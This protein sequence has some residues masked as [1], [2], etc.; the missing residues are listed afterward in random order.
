MSNISFFEEVNNCFDKASRHTSIDQGLLKCIKVCNSSY[1]VTFPLVRDNGEVE[2]VQA[3]RAEHSHH[4]LPTK[5]GIRYSEMVNEDEVMAL[6]ALMTYKC[7]IVDVPFGGAKGGIQINARQLSEKERERLTRRYTYELVRKGFIGPGV[8]VPAPDYGTGEQEMAWIVDAFAALNPQMDADACVTGKPVALSGIRG[9]TEATGRGVF[10]GI[11]E[12]CAV[13]EDMEKLGLS[14]GLEGKKIIV[15]GL[16]NVGYHSA[17]FF[18]QAGAMIVG[19]MEYEGGIYNDQG[20]N[21][22]Q[23]VDHRRANNSILGFPG[24][25]N[26]EDSKQGLELPCDILVPAALEHQISEE[27]APR[28]QAKIIAEAANGP[29][30][31]EAHEILVKKGVLIVPDIYLNAGGVTVSYFE[32]LK[33]ISHVRFGRIGKRFEQSSQNSMLQAIEMATGRKFSEEE[34]KL[35]SKDA[36]EV[37]LVDSGLEDTMVNAYGEIWETHK[38]HNVDLRIASFINAINKVAVIYQRRGIFP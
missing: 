16:G 13:K 22:Q 17:N 18:E 3:W 30:T 38:R 33:N 25:R 27:N 21:L 35:L 4:K 20:L 6:A 32:W 36:D 19:V 9:R 28:I 31:S 2:V 15:Q 1:H 34:R 11:R 12:A 14:P 5:G 23:V 10:F 37:T 8:D 26:I 7:A 24:S 29:L